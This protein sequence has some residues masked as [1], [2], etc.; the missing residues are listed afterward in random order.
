MLLAVVVVGALAAVGVVFGGDDGDDGDSG[1]QEPAQTTPREQER[2]RPAR[3]RRVRLRIAPVTPTYVCID[4]G[5]GTPIVFEGTLDAPRTFRGRILRVNLGKTD[6]RLG[7]NGRPIAV[8]PGPEPVGF[9][10]T[11]R[12]HRS[13]PPAKRP[14]V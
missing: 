6:V 11:A 7:A 12:S 13:L 1:E 3:P 5:A 14:C 2:E 10:F 8:V 9:R 4:R